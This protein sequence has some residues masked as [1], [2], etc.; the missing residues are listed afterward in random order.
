MQVHISYFLLELNV[1]SDI[2]FLTGLSMP[3]SLTTRDWL[4][5]QKGGFLG[6]QCSFDQN[7][8]PEIQEFKHGVEKCRRT[9]TNTL[10]PWAFQ[11]TI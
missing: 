11:V 8:A 5:D 3:C 9:I 1:P 2:I 6:I 7:M 10:P 4:V